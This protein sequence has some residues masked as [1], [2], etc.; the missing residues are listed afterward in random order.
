MAIAIV[1]AICTKF[2]TE[3]NMKSGLPIVYSSLFCVELLCVV[4]YFI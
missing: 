4:E 1:N 3:Y 2:N